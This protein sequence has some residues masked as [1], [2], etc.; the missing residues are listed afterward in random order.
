MLRLAL[1][2]VILL[3]LRTARLHCDPIP[4]P[5]P[6]IPNGAWSDVLNARPRLLGPQEHLRAL[7]Q[8]KPTVYAEIKASKRLVA[9]GIVNAVEGAPPAD[10]APHIAEAIKNVARGATNLHQ[11]TWIYLKQVALTYDL[12]H[13][14]ISPANRAK[15]IDWLNAHLAAYTTDENAFHNS[16]L[17]KILVYLQIAYA[18]WGENPQAQAFRDRALTSLYEGKLLPVLLEFGAGGGYTEC[19]WYT[20]GSL[21]NLVEG[22]ELARRIEGYDGFAKAPGFFYQRLAYEMLQPYPGLWTYGAEH[23][24]VE[25]DGAATYGGHNEYPRHMRTV[26][27]QY[28]R[29]S[30]L[31]RQIANKR[32]TGSN[33]EARLFDFLYEE[34][35]DAATPIADMPLAHLASGIGKLYARS[36]W[37]DDATWFRFECGDFWCNHQH[38][39]TGNFEIYRRE[40]LATESGEYHDWGSPHAMNWLI[41]TIAHNCILVNM[42]GETWTHMRDGDR[43]PIANDG[44]QAKKFDWPAD[45]LADWKAKRDTFT[46]GKI[47][48]YENRPEYLYVAGDCSQAYAAAKLQSWIRQIIFL[49]PDT[50]ETSK[51][52]GG[53]PPAAIPHLAVDGSP[54]SA[55]ETHL[56]DRC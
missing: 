32:R 38:Y 7:A 43:V 5:A 36:D 6:R 22:L 54:G 3:G 23:Y 4:A 13:D 52:P 46:R 56:P 16:T 24:A 55:G 15:M 19:G 10:T 33:F 25:G 9:V 48:A 1:M 39:E 50:L 53:T 49:R 31:S 51:K 34:V 2:I 11:D 18:T 14:S 27:A 17:T 42:P 8:A 47:V 41:R 35:P 40:P 45:T 30:D 21:W 44:G 26:L 29:G 28:F 37:T 12:F 20:R